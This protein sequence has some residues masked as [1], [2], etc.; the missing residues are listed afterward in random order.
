MKRDR[1]EEPPAHRLGIL[2]VA[3][4]CMI[5][6]LSGISQAFILRELSWQSGAIYSV[7]RSARHRSP[8][9]SLSVLATAILAASEPAER[10][11]LEDS[12]RN[13]IQLNRHEGSA[14]SPPGGGPSSV[15]QPGLEV[16]SRCNGR[17]RRTVRRRSNQLNHCSLSSSGIGRR[18]RGPR[19]PSRSCESIIAE[20]GAFSRASAEAAQATADVVAVRIQRIE[21]FEYTLFGLVVV[22]LVARGTVR[23]QPR[24]PEDPAD[25]G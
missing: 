6:L 5:A 9:D 2:Y 20:E 17:P 8:D 22:V 12:L 10:Q 3:S 21:S 14:M 11:E 24:G 16:F 7:A 4:F 1:R 18:H 15:K 13:A 19:N 23:G 25:H